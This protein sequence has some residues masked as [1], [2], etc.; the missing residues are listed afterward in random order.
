MRVTDM[1]KLEVFDND[2]LRCILRC[3]RIDRVATHALRS[4]LHLRPLPSILHHRRLRWF[5]HAAR[6]PEGELIR[7]LLLPSPLPGWRKRAG[8]QLKNWA[9]V[10]KDDLAVLSGPKVVGLR[11]WNRDWLA[12]SCD[13][14]QDRRTW[15]SMVRDAVRA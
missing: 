7:G 10:I 8:G 14:A 13:L 12:I 15:A 4:R 11:V 3:R 1:R 5:G 6:R 2:C 9:G